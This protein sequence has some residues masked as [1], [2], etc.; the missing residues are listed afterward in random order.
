VKP[1]RSVM[2]SFLVSCL[3]PLTA[4]AADDTPV[5]ALCN[6]AAIGNVSQVQQH[7]AA[8]TNL[9]GQDNRGRTPLSAA[10]IGGNVEVVTLLTKAGAD[11]TIDTRQ[12]APVI[13]AIQRG[14][15]DI[16]RVFVEQGGVDVNARIAGI[17]PL[18][19]ARRHPDIAAYLQEKGAVEPTRLG[20]SPYDMPQPG[21]PQARGVQ[22]G[23]GFNNQPDILADP[24]AIRAKIRAVPGLEA[25]LKVLDAN[26]TSNMRSWRQ[27]RVDNRTSL[28]RSTREQFQDE[29]RLVRTLAAK[30]TGAASAGVAQKLSSLVGSLTGQARSAEPNNATSGPQLVPAIDDLVTRRTVRYEV[31][32]EALREQRREI[33]RQER[34]AN[35]NSRGRGR[36]RGRGS[37]GR[38]T[39][40]AVPTYPTPPRPTTLRGNRPEDASTEPALDPD[41]ESQLT[42]W[43]G[44]NPEDK[45]DLLNTVYEMDIAEYGALH[46]IA[47]A[48]E[49][50]HTAAAVAGLMLAHQEQL[51]AVLEKMRA[52]DERLQRQAE[53]NTGLPQEQS[54]G[55]RGRRSR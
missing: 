18:H 54:T 37:R 20:D 48:A 30:E 55:R 36:G 27:R 4:P 42:A 22:P 45:R 32:Y 16:V 21:V 51:D 41:T 34:E 23:P 11:P 47:E 46:Q 40:E 19:A 13:A 5:T 9:N 3:L 10:V 24:N 29:M 7:I 44:A 1:L 43:L 14:K 50:P 8:G 39:T 53:R 26:G 15:L 49:A 33:L 35:A 12:G 25:K 31:I 28:L 52:D 17:T 2:I 6:A 38:S